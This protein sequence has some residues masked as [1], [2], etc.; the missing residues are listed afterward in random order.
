MTRAGPPLSPG[1]HAC[2]SRFVAGMSVSRPPEDM[3][4]KHAATAP[5]N[6]QGL[7]QAAGRLTVPVAEDI[8][9]FLLDD[10]QDQV[11][12]LVMDG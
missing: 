8:H 4:A 11:V 10:G 12:R 1:C 6:D 7:P 2:D 9:G 3:P 5:G